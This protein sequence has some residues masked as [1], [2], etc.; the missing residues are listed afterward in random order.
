MPCLLRTLKKRGGELWIIPTVNNPAKR[1]RVVTR[2]ECGAL[3]GVTRMCERMRQELSGLNKICHVDQDAVAQLMTVAVFNIV[4]AI[5]W[6]QTANY[7]A[8]RGQLRDLQALSE[9]LE[10]SICHSGHL[11]CSD[12]WDLMD[13]L[14]PRYRA[15][16]EHYL[17]V[18]RTAHCSPAHS[19][20]VDTSD[21]LL[22]S[23]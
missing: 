1:G 16:T 15:I 2:S 5:I 9:Q 7:K 23:Q 8:R 18:M 6:L 10:L 14:E 20:F 17:L 21:G 11:V 4:I 19:G 12:G 3:V 13:P 22:V